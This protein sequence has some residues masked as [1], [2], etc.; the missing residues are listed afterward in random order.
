MMRKRFFLL[1]N[2][3][4]ADNVPTMIGRVVSDIY[5]PLNECAPWQQE[6]RSLLEDILPEPQVSTNRKE[7][8]EFA[9]GPAAFAKISK[10]FRVDIERRSDDGTILESDMI[11]QYTLE[12]PAK[13]FEA[14]M[15]DGAYAADIWELLKERHPHR[16]YLITGFLTTTNSNWESNRLLG[17]SQT[18]SATAPVAEVLG[19]P[20]PGLDLGVG[21]S[22]NGKTKHQSSKTVEKEEIFAVAYN[23]VQLKR[24]RIGKNSTRAAVVGD[25][26]WAKKKHAALSQDKNRQSPSAMDCQ[27][28]ESD[29][30]ESGGDESELDEIS[31]DSDN[32]PLSGKFDDVIEIDVEVD[33]KKRA[34]I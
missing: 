11:K 24:T 4:S 33:N 34:C 25:I 17:I 30:D 19:A 31:L 3:C 18:I 16:A 5:E 13:R 7:C 10:L 26:V 14:L 20:I 6:A 27:G 29:G 2:P 28:E 32:Q 9:R 22:Y 8:L 21:I 23:V 12:N 15:K 1:N